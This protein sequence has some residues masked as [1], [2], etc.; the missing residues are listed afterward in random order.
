MFLH[1][2]QEFDN[3]FRARTNK[4]LALAGFLSVV[5]SVERVIKYARLDHI[6]GEIL[7]STKGGEVS[8]FGE[9]DPY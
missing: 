2:T 9:K 6:C 5:D 1:D 7:N 4:D 3:D 8:A